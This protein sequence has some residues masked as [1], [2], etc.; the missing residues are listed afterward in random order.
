[1]DIPGVL[2]V[3]HANSPSNPA[4][5][6]LRPNQTPPLSQHFITDIW[7]ADL[8][9]LSAGQLNPKSRLLVTHLSNRIRNASVDCNPIQFHPCS[10]RKFLY[11]TDC[12]IGHR[13]CL[14]QSVSCA[15][16]HYL[17]SPT[18]CMDNI[19]FPFDN[20]TPIGIHLNQNPLP[21]TS[22]L[23]HSFHRD[24]FCVLET[25]R[26]IVANEQVPEDF[27]PPRHPF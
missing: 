21:S 3:H 4:C 26:R 24:P 13:S 1:M 27:K 25:P 15:M 5:L 2:D 14:R 11:Y 7:F 10:E 17:N 19:T 8:L 9:S 18:P 12:F 22:F 23:P 6:Y 16:L 20:A